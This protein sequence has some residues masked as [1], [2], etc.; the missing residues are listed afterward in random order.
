[1]LSNKLATSYNTK[2]A[3]K[4]IQKSKKFSHRLGF[5]SVF[6][7]SFVV[8]GLFLFYQS[9]RVP[10]LGEENQVTVFPAEI[11]NILGTEIGPQLFEKQIK[12]P[13][14][15]YHYVEY[16]KDD[17]GRQKLTTP[18]N[19]LMAQIETLRDAGYTFITPDDLMND[20]SGQ[21]IPPEKLIILTFD[22]GYMDF[23][24]DVFPILNKEN[25]KAI[26]Y[27]VPDLLNR[28]NY[29]F[30]FQVKEIAKS[31]LVEI[32]SH[33]MN[34][35]WLKGISKKAA[36]YEISQSRKVLQDMVALP[37]NSFAYPYGA[38]DQ[39]AIN[40][41]RETGYTNAVS[42]IPG[43][44]QAMQSKFFLYR[45]RPGYKT[46]EELIKFLAQKD[47]KAE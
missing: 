9:R 45:L 17:P 2:V 27:I 3:R 33:T 47:F 10:E 40:V 20:L 31:P 21:T 14:F 24:T 19:I 25:V 34:H 8:L 43:I 4:K 29:M 6:I 41:V 15:L 7:V 36:E 26:V 38:L 46:G 18:P 37:I 28:P 30:T 44:V 22:D 42:T 12:V 1:M 13:V 32:G 35:V 39:R 16:V 11:L 23:Y 5:I